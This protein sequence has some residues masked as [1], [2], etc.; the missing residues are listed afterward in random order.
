M[1]E[2][3]QT[4]G[5]APDRETAITD[6][7]AELTPLFYADLRRISRQVRRGAPGGP[8]RTLDTTALIHEAWLKLSVRPRWNDRQH[9]LRAAALAMRQALVDDARARLAGRRNHAQGA[10]SL[11]AAAEVAAD[12]P[13]ER[14]IAVHEALAELSAFAPRLAQTVE[15]R[16]F[17]GYTES[18]T[19]EALGVGLA[20]VQRDW[21]KA[22][23]WLFQRLAG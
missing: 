20:T 8:A 22:R 2:M 4:P 19:A 11:D 9:F 12:A 15:C 10:L 16:Y 18:E 5:D 13:D 17:A 14:V 3:S 6:I 23:A 7:A 1:A 21:A